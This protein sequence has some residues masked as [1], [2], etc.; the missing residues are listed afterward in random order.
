MMCFVVLSKI[1]ITT[2]GPKVADAETGFPYSLIIPSSSAG[3]ED[4][5]GM[6][7]LSYQTKKSL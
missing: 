6:M 4:D 5:V 1:K 7:E 2:F 3:A